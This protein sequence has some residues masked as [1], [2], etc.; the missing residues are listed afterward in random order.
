MFTTILFLSSFFFFDDESENDVSGYGSSSTCPFPFPPFLF[1][2]VNSVGCVSGSGSEIV[3]CS[4]SFFN[5]ERV[6]SFFDGETGK[7]GRVTGIFPKLVESQKYFPKLFESQKYFPA[8]KL[9]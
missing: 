2:P 6:N 1:P 4:F 5:G 7:V 3:K 8:Q 9:S